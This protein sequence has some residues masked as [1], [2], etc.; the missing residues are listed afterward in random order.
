M[1]QT[2]TAGLLCLGLLISTN[3]AAENVFYGQS[4]IYSLVVPPGWTVADGR[5]HS[6][7]RIDS[8][9]GESRGG[10]FV[11]IASP[12]ANLD[13]EASNVDNPTS[14]QT[15]TVDGFSCLH[16]THYS[17]GP[18]NSIFCQFTAPFQ[19]GPVR[20]TFFLGQLAHPDEQTAQE[21]AFWETVRSVQFREGT[22]P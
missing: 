15:I 17:A 19:D 21:A 3:S 13:D 6:D 9:G 2:W 4:D 14:K 11:G 16:V 5:G 22:L 18:G 8:P 12:K 1:L 10:M 20:L 7:A